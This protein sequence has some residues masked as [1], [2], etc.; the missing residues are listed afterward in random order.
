[1]Y[2]NKHNYIYIMYINKILLIIMKRVLGELIPAR[3]G[4]T[5]GFIVTTS[6]A[7][8]FAFCF[9]QQQERCV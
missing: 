9:T 4:I 1:M 7:F 3:G 8:F 6:I 2:I 5:S